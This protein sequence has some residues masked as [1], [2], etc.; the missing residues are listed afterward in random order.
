MQ[1]QRLGKGK[2]Q[3]RGEAGTA[4]FQ[5]FDI[6]VTADFHTPIVH[7]VAELA[8][9]QHPG[10]HDRRKVFPLARTEHQRVNRQFADVGQHIFGAFGKIDDHGRDQTDRQ[11]ENLFRDPGR[12]NVRQVFGAWRDFDCPHHT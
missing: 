11:A 2:S 9:A 12:R 1:H 5:A 10:L 3:A 6:N 8:R 4:P 7:Q